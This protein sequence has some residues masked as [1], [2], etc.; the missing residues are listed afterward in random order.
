MELLPAPKI[1][2]HKHLIDDVIFPRPAA[3]GYIDSN[4]VPVRLHYQRGVDPLFAIE[5]LGYVE[6]AWEKLFITGNFMAPHPDGTFGGNSLFDI[7]IVT[8][9]SPGVGGMAGFSGYYEP[10]SR[11]D[12]ISYVV[13]NHV[14]VD[15]LRRNYVSSQIKYFLTF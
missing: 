3:I 14:I 2:D 15:R 6:T 4:R 1:F 11:I 7:Y 13:F 12:A 9:L 8:N 5:M 10:T